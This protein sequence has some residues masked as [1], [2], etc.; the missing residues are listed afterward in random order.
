MRQVIHAPDAQLVQ[1]LLLPVSW[2]VP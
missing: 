1:A 2:V